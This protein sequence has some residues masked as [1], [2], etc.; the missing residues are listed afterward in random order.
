MDDGLVH[1]R[2][3]VEL[4]FYGHPKGDM[5]LTDGLIRFWL[6]HGVRPGIMDELLYMCGNCHGLLKY[7]HLEQ[8]LM[9]PHCGA[10]L[11]EN[12][13]D[14]QMFSDSLWGLA[15]KVAAHVR[16]LRNDVDIKLMR[17]KGGMTFHQAEFDPTY[18]KSEQ[19]KALNMI[20]SSMEVAIYPKSRLEADLAAG[21]DLVTR[22]EAFFHA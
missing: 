10:P 3:L 15:H 5:T 14:G 4:T 12:Y 9:C 19:A 7:E 11:T 6:N 22:L 13:H 8:R 16:S 2:Y 18:S 20:Q 1:G 21:A 17:K